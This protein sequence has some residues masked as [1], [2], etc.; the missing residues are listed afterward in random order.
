[1]QDGHIIIQDF[2]VVDPEHTVIHVCAV[3]APDCCDVFEFDTPVCD[4]SCALFDLFAE[5]GQCT[6]DSTF[7]LDVVFDAFNLPVDSVTIYVGDLYIGTFF[8]DP[9]YIHIEDFP[10]FDGESTTIIVCAVG[11]PDCCDTY[12][13]ENPNCSGE[14]DILELVVDPIE[15]NSDSTF[16]LVINFDWI[17][18]DAGGFDVY[19]GDH[20]LGF[21]G[22]DQV[23]ITVTNFPSNSTGNYVVTV[24][25]SDNQECCE[26]LEF[27][28]PVCGEGGC[29]IF[30]ITWEITEC[31]KEG[32]FWFIID[33]EFENVGGEGFNVHGNG[34]NYGNF[35]YDDLPI[36]LG[37]FENGDT[38][39]E[40]AIQD[41]QF[42]DCLGVIVPG[43]V[44]CNVATNE[45][46][47]DDIFRIDNNGTV[48]GVLS[49]KDINL[50][51]FNSNGKRIVLNKI[52]PEGEFYELKDLPS[53]IYMGSIIYQENIW[54]VKL[55]KSAE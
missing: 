23:P 35:G 51:L 26:T 54:T 45:I 39:W 10:L 13:F 50:S 17:N 4:G 33:F 2:P 55:V 27:E 36:E 15:C 20:Y 3:G 9:E 44:D 32:Q 25:E 5:T 52:I 22:L 12:T 38:E 53:G 7:V 34:N 1:V 14:C 37:P 6:S 40:F 21:F 48:P 8:N 29:A 49:L 47:H 30:D 11:A 43:V 28:G 18:V 24:C 19:A 42:G 31:N 46:S 16:I 41:N